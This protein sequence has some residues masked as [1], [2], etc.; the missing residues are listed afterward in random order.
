MLRSRVVTALIL[1]PLA[2]WIVWWAPTMVLPIVFLVVAGMAAYEMAGLAGL[3]AS[4]QRLL[5]GAAVAGLAGG[6]VLSPVEPL[7]RIGAGAALWLAALG[8][9]VLFAV[10]RRVTGTVMM[11]GLVGAA[12]IVATYDALVSL[13]LRPGDGAY[14]VTMLFVLVWGSDIGGYFAG[15]ALGRRPLAPRVS[16]GKTVE[17]A[18]GGLAL[19][20]V[21][22]IGFHLALPAA[23]VGQPLWVAAGAVVI[24]VAIAGDLF[25]SMLKRQVGAKDSG[26]LLPGHGGVL[27]RIDALIAAAPILALLVMLAD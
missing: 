26:H 20:L 12:L 1:A 17:G 24:A 11:R 4:R 13:H 18:V 14:W 3:T 7:L 6:V 21:A 10:G 2:L 15:R 25:E 16:P 8:W 22:A 27:D 19:G 23:P 9:M 5:F